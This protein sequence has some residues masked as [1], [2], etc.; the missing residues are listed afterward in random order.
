MEYPEGETESPLVEITQAGPTWDNQQ[1]SSQVGFQS[2]N[3]ERAPDRPPMSTKRSIPITVISKMARYVVATPNQGEVQHRQLCST[4]APVLP[5]THAHQ[6]NKVATTTTSTPAISEQ[7]R[8]PACSKNYAFVQ[9]AF[10]QPFLQQSFR[11][12]F[13]HFFPPMLPST[14]TPI[15]P[16]S[17]QPSVTTLTQ[18]P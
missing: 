1:E 16:P 4:L 7:S 15:L 14:R 12:S 9:N 17:Q 18:K 11:K 6:G 5:S 3:I 13:L 10:L 2:K 8:N